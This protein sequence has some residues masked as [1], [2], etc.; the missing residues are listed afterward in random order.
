MSKDQELVRVKQVIK[1]VHPFCLLFRVAGVLLK[2][3][4][5]KWRWQQNRNA[6]ISVRRFAEV[7]YKSFQIYMTPGWP[8]SKY[9]Y[10]YAG[11][12]TVFAIDRSSHRRYSLKKGVLR[13]FAKFTGKHPFLQLIKNT[14]SGTG[15]LL[16]ILR[17]F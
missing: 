3:K 9:T 15:V 10:I 17:N 13:K 6:E 16:W 2:K 5:K 14:D 4:V 8:R 11:S 12:S 1:I 7:K